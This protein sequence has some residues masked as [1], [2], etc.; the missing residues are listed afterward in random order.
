MIV[1]ASD[2][3]GTFDLYQKPVRGAGEE[4]LLLHTDEPKSAASWTS[5]GKYIAYVTRSPKTQFDIWALPASGDGKPIPLAVSPFTETTPMFSPDGRY[6]TYVSNE[7]GRDEI[8]V[9]TFPEPGGK[10]QVSNGGGSD[11]SWRGDGKE[12]YYRSPDQK[13]MAVEIRPGADFQAGVPQALFAIR[14]RPG[15]PRNKYVP[16]SDGQRFMIAAPLGRDAM[17]PTTIVL[18]WPAGL[19][20]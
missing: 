5:N 17:S 18:N 7:S 2:R 10:W 19:G 4:K 11:P 6:V 9:Q 8:Y 14:I 12:L 3:A 16:S 20:K 15:G 1:F 13:L